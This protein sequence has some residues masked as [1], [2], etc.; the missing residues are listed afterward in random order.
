[1]VLFLSGHSQPQSSRLPRQ[2]TRQT[3]N[4]ALPSE[5]RRQPARCAYHERVNVSP[6]QPASD[7]APEGQPTQRR[8]RI[9]NIRVSGDLEAL[10]MLKNSAIIAKRKGAEP[11]WP[12]FL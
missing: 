1:M 6:E 2:T 5:Q 4:P 8:R 9:T 11:A 7:L 10:Q 12:S 3:A